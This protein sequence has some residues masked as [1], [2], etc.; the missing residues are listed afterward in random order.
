MKSDEKPFGEEGARHKDSKEDCH[1]NP[2]GLFKKYIHDIR[3]LK[4]L[5]KEMLRNIRD[6]STEEKMNIIIALNDIV[7]YLKEILN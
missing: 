1:H 6:M 5:D 4:A 7:E 3:N 2:S